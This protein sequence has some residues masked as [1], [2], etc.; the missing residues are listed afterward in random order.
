MALGY[1]D[2]CLLI[3]ILLFVVS[4]LYYGFIHTVGNLI[5]MVV[6]IFLAGYGILWLQST[7]QIFSQPIAAILI[8]LLLILFISR[9]VGWLVDLVD[10]FWKILSIIPFLG[11]INKLLG[12]IFGF[13]EGMIVVA[14]LVYF[15][16]TYL[17]GSD[18]TTA[19]LAAPVTGWLAWTIGVVK[20]LFPIVTA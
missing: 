15:S 18:I 9:L 3:M 11:P 7:L 6:G 12:G 19:I 20:I 16:T 8:F 13:L 17:P 10:Q 5:G 2:I 4:G 14:S 1:V